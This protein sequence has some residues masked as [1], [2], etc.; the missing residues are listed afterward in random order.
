MSLSRVHAFGKF[1]FHIFYFSMLLFYLGVS[2][3]YVLGI[4]CVLI[5][6]EK[7]KTN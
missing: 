7:A 4:D 6:E 2:S 5:Q 3:A 1:N